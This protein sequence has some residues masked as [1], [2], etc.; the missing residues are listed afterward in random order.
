M[1]KAFVIVIAFL[2]LMP[3]MGVAMSMHN[4]GDKL[5]H[6]DFFGFDK[7]DCG[8]GK[9]KMK[10]SCCK[11]DFLYFKIK[12]AYKQSNIETVI[13]NI[14]ASSYN[15][16]D[17]RRKDLFLKYQQKQL[18]IKKDYPSLNNCKNSIYINYGCFRI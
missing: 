12:D 13:Y 14:V 10:S 3:S 4:C 9:K 16:N 7:K 11:D 18:C 8:C 2:Y 6:V 5:S 17:T 1:K 15:I